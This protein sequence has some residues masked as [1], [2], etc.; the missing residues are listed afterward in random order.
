MFVINSLFLEAHGSNPT[1]SQ[2]QLSR[3]YMR[4]ELSSS[5]CVHDNNKFVSVSMDE[6]KE[7]KGKY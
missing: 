3:F 6:S 4:I 7:G 2:S 5:L 1:L